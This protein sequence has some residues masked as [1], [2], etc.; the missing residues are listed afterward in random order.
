MAMKGEKI[1]LEETNTSR[2]EPMSSA[3][4]TL[5][6]MAEAQKHVNH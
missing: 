6:V 4:Y 2:Q 5:Y 3:K 1:F